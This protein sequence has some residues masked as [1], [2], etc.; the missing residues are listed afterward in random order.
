MKLDGHTC[1]GK[2][3]LQNKLSQPLRLN[4]NPKR[5]WVISLAG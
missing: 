3:L 5:K 4:L 2:I 1:M